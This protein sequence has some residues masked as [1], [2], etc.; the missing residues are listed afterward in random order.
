MST[1]NGN[2]SLPP[3]FNLTQQDIQD[4]ALFMFNLFA[5]NVQGQAQARAAETTGDAIASMIKKNAFRA[6]NV[7]FFDSQ[8]DSFYGS[9]DVV[10]VE[11]DLYYRDVYLFVERVKDVVI[12]SDVEA[13]QTNLSTCLKGSAQ[14]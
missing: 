9:G 12:M 2:A 7:G 4:I 10:Q 3:V 11:R 8:L 13:V 1:T 14:I 5:Q 6:S